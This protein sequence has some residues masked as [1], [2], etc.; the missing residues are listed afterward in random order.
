M[1]G[2]AA[3]L[4]AVAMTIAA[5]VSAATLE[6]IYARFRAD[7]ATSLQNLAKIKTAE[8][9]MRELGFT[10][11]QGSSI[12]AV[13]HR[14]GARVEVTINRAKPGNPV[15]IGHGNV[16]FVRRIPGEKDIEQ[17]HDFASIGDFNLAEFEST[18][19]D[20]KS[21]YGPSRDRAHR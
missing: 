17:S 2:K 15:V 19:Q 20:V 3:Y 11:Q 8:S 14:D 9:K 13:L 21:S 18:V 6:E 7:E 1:H 4:F 10:L 16:K 12:N 5:S